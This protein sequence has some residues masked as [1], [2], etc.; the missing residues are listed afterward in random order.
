MTRGAPPIFV[1]MGEDDTVTPA[2]R[3][4]HF[5]AA[6]AKVGSRCDLHTYPKLGHLLTRNLDPRAQETGPFDTDPAA[7]ADARAKADRFLAELGYIKG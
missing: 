4:R 1:Y 5:C 6:M 7:A 3:A 2:I